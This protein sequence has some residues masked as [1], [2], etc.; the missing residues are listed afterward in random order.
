LTRDRFFVPLLLLLEGALVFGELLTQSFLG[1]G[2]FLEQGQWNLE[3]PPALSTHCD[4]G[5]GAQPFFYTKVARWHSV[6]DLESFNHKVHRG[7][8]RKSPGFNALYPLGE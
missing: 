6:L 8:Q 5:H 3:F 1:V 7:T 4:G 2:C